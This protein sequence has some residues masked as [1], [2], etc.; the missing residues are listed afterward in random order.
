MK[1]FSKEKDLIHRI[2]NL[3]FVV[4][5]IAAVVILYISMVEL[6]FKKPSD[7]FET[8]KAKIC[9]GMTDEACNESY[10]SQQY[11]EKLDDYYKQIASINAAGNMVIVGTATYL[12]NRPSK[13]EKTNKPTKKNK[14]K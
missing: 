11:N 8:Y 12:I 5:F 1:L 14:S 4:W 7:N 13:E 6:L 2:V 9:A 10:A 3:I